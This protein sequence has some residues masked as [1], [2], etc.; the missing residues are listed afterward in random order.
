MSLVFGCFGGGNGPV[1]HWV[2][3][4]ATASRTSAGLSRWRRRRRRR[5]V[6]RPATPPGRRFPP[7]PAVLPARLASQTCPA[8]TALPSKN[9]SRTSGCSSPMASTTT[10]PPLKT[11]TPRSSPRGFRNGFRPKTRQTPS[12]PTRRL[13]GR[14]ERYRPCCHVRFRNCRVFAGRT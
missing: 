14:W 12:Q 13:G 10:A 6:R 1:T 11:S 2:S 9:S 8:G 7:R 3:E 4:M 5:W